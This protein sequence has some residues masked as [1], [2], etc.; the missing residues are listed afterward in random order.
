MGGSTPQPR[1]PNKAPQIVPINLRKQSWKS[2]KSWQAGRHRAIFCLVPCKV[3]TKAHPPTPQLQPPLCVHACVPAHQPPPSL[4]V[5]QSRRVMRIKV[6]KRKK[7]TIYGIPCLFVC[8]GMS[9]GA[10]SVRGFRSDF[11]RHFALYMR[12]TGADHLYSCHDW[13]GVA[14]QPRMYAHTHTKSKTETG[15][16]TAWPLSAVL[17]SACVQLPILNPFGRRSL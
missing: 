1:F 16:G 12:T 9:A 6:P 15:T 3:M 11:P 14:L 13:T 5:L 2:W 17:Q 8:V 10:S 7:R 4:Q